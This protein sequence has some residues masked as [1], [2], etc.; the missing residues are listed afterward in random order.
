MGKWDVFWEKMSH[1][2]RCFLALSRDGPG[3]EVRV[4]F[5]VEIRGN[6]TNNFF[7]EGEVEVSKPHQTSTLSE[8]M[9]CIV[10]QPHT[11]F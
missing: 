3:S 1:L 8:Y 7:S 5:L 11:C 2:G 10:V 6:L 4:R 9:R